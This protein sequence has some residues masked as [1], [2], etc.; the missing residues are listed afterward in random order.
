MNQKIDVAFIDGDHTYSGVKKDYDIYKKFVKPGGF[1]VFH[2]IVPHGNK[3]VGVPQFWKEIREKYEYKE[4]V[5]DWNQKWG[6]IGLLF[7]K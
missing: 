5:E 7:I 4:F 2:D 3:R 1:M 6:G